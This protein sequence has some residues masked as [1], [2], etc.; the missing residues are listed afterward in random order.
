[1]EWATVAAGLETH[2]ISLGFYFNRFGWQILYFGGLVI[3]FFMAKGTMDF[4]LMHTRK[5][6]LLLPALGLIAAFYASS[7]FIALAGADHMPWVEAAFDRENMTLLRVGV[8]CAYIYTGLWLLMSGPTS[9]HLIVRARSIALHALVTARPLVFLGQHSLQVFVWQA[10]L[11]YLV[12][13]FASPLL[14]D[15]PL[16]MIE[17]SLIL[18][19]LSLLISA[20][21]NVQ[22]RG[23]RSDMRHPSALPKQT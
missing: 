8:F 7:A 10:C 18:A 2:D 3:G 4:G 5:A 22:Y 9:R 15:Q 23:W 20:W 17:V 11:I 6:R 16:V 13:A 12:A 1:M 19:A 21:L 14:E